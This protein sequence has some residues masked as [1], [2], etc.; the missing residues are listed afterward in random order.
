MNQSVPL[1]EEMYQY[2]LDN[3]DI[4]LNEQKNDLFALYFDLT[5]RAG[6]TGNGTGTLSEKDHDDRGI[7]KD[8]Q[9]IR[10]GIH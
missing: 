6:S 8:V 3:Q 5:K 10:Q 7:C 4:L 9:D 1:I 2:L